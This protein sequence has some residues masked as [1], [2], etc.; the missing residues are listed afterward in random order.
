MWGF[1]KKIY[2]IL[3]EKESKQERDGWEGQRERET[4]ADSVLNREPNCGAQS[5]DP[6]IGPE[7]KPRI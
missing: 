5:H 7:L 2:F 4:R 3:F 1:F 6:E